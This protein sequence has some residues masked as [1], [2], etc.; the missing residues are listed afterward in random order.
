MK[1]NLFICA[2]NC[3]TLELNENHLL[4][5]PPSYEHTFYANQGNEFLVFY[6][7]EMI[8]LNNREFEIKYLNFDTHWQ[9]LRSLMLNEIDV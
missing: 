6:I 1:G 8:F 5:L 4:L 9:A 2:K 3:Q 7:P